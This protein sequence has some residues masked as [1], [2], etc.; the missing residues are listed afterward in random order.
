[1]NKTNTHQQSTNRGIEGPGASASAGR[2][3]G[4]RVCGVSIKMVMSDRES[5]RQDRREK[6]VLGVVSDIMYERV[7]KPCKRRVSKATL[8]G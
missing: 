8:Q 6:I 1:M 3:R 7:S 5:A 4:D 2:K